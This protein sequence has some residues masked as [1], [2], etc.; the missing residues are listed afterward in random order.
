MGFNADEFKTQERQLSDIESVQAPVQDNSEAESI[1]AFTRSVQSMTGLVSQVGSAVRHS[2]AETAAEAKAAAEAQ[3][4]EYSNRYD[5]AIEKMSAAVGSEQMSSRQA[6]VYLKQ[7]KD[8][9]INLGASADAL[10]TSEVKSLKTLSGKALAEGSLEERRQRAEEKEYQGSKWFNASYTEEEHNAAKF[11]MNT[12]QARELSLAAKKREAEFESV[13]AG[14]DEVKR[15]VADQKI[16]DIKIEAINNLLEESPTTLTNETSRI[17]A[18]YAEEVETLGEPTA[19]VNAERSAKLFFNGSRRAGD[20]LSAETRDGIP[21]QNDAYKRTVTEY[22]E[23]FLA[24]LG[25]VNLSEKMSEVLAEQQIKTKVALY[26]SSASIRVN[27]A[28]TDLLGPNAA[29]YMGELTTLAATDA[30]DFAVATI[31]R[32]LGDN[33]PPLVVG[34]EAAEAVYAQLADNLAASANGTF[35]GET[36]TLKKNVSGHLAHMADNMDKLSTKEVDGMLKAYADPNFGKFI[37]ANGLS[38]ED[39]DNAKRS[40]FD[41]KEKV[42]DTFVSFVQGAIQ[43]SEKKALLSKGFPRDRVAAE[44]IAEK[45]DFEVVYEGEQVMVRSKTEAGRYKASQ[46]NDR[47]SGP[48]TRI[49]NV[50]SNLSGVSKEKIFNNWLPQLWPEEEAATEA[51]EVDNSPT[52]TQ[53][54]SALPAGTVIIDAEGNRF[55]ADGNGNVTQIRS[56]SNAA[57]R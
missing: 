13:Q 44:R 52:A 5:A 36:A 29:N 43:S 28:V 26:N 41:Y 34:S 32:E 47:I 18:K 39:L 24:N 56:A 6:Q 14:R 33:P 45:E 48:L 12:S 46:W 25:E 23:V 49:I 35:K 19:R 2:R 55:T 51:V 30:N 57:S 11:K 9:L 1:S 17:M 22:E 42:A 3:D 40:I 37:K 27:N 7:A 20:Q 15:K 21:V 8:E 38:N 31:K 4:I 16:E 10:N 54:L 50:D 53:D